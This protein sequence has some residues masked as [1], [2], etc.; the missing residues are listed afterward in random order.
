MWFDG[1]RTNRLSRNGVTKLRV[2]LLS[3]GRPASFSDTTIR[4]SERFYSSNLGGRLCSRPSGSAG[5]RGAPAARMAGPARWP[6]SERMPSTVATL[7]RRQLRDVLNAKIG[8]QMS[9]VY[10]GLNGTNPAPCYYPLTR[11]IKALKSSAIENTIFWIELTQWVRPGQI[12]G[13]RNKNG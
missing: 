2:R 6:T 10:A 8:L 11:L 13:A 3:I 4:R 5:I 9:N 1:E 7:A 12:L